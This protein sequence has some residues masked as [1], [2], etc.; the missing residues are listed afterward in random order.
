MKMPSTVVTYSFLNI[1]FDHLSLSIYIPTS[2]PQDE[3]LRGVDAMATAKKIVEFMEL[4]SGLIFPLKF[5]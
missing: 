3:F 5:I 1:W 4:V 2:N